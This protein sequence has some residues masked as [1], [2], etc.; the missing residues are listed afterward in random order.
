M[1]IKMKFEKEKILQRL[2]TI[3]RGMF[4]SKFEIELRGKL[5]EILST[6]TDKK[7]AVEAIIHHLS[8]NINAQYA[9]Q[10]K[11]VRVF[12]NFFSRFIEKEKLREVPPKEWFTFVFRENSRWI[13]FEQNINNGRI[14]LIKNG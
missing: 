5:A 10:A 9:F 11:A 3:P 6:S 7:T 13:Y 12:Y 2:N 4:V 1:A 14:K 8:Y